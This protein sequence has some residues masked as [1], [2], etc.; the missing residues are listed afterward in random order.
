[1]EHTGAGDGVNATEASAVEN[2][3][4]APDISQNFTTLESADDGGTD[5]RSNSGMT[6]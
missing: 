5:A 2:V 4:S 1:M 3:T 6:G